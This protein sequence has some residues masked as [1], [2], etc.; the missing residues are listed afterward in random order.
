M[1]DMA[2]QLIGT[3]TDKQRRRAVEELNGY[4]ERLTRLANYR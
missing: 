2:A 4:S 3:L 1:N